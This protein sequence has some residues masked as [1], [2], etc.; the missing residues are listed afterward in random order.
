MSDEHNEA[1]HLQHALENYRVP[2][3]LLRVPQEREF[4]GFRPSF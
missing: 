2:P 1:F 3:K 4:E